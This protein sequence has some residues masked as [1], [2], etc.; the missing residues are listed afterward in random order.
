MNE[1]NKYLESI[2]KLYNSNLSNSEKSSKLSTLWTDY[3]KK[4]HELGIDLDE[5]YNLY[6]LG[7]NE[8]YIIEWKPKKKLEHTQTPDRSRARGERNGRRDRDDSPL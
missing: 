4:S 1:L 6:L 5:A 3:Y 2:R 8:S 7:E